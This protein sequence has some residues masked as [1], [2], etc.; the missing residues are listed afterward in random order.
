M[1]LKDLLE[2]NVDNKYYLTEKG[3][4]RLIKK[5]NKLIREMQNP[6][7]SACIIAGY[8][9]MDGRDSQYVADENNTVKRIGGIYDN[10]KT[11]HQSGSIYNPNGISP[12]LVDMSKGGSNQPMVL[13][14]EGT[15]RGFSC[16]TLGDSI[17][18]S[19]PNNT[20][21]RGRIGKEL[22]QTIVTAP[23]I[24]TLEMFNPYN[25]RHITDIAPTQTANCNSTTSSSTVLISENN[26]Y[27]LRIRKLTPLECFRL[28]GFDDIDFNKLISIGISDTQLYKQAR[29]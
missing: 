17:N 21:K 16:A 15:N 12:T 10:E 5:N 1:K 14:N 19:Y 26:K 23:N 6:N 29:K 11:K 3:I 13:V 2:T 7:I 18:I 9:K 28:M 27:C 25:N 22:S 4:G 24:A 8:S 20:R